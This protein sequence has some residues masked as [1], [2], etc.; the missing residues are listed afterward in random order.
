MESAKMM[1]EI[2]KVLKDDGLYLAISYGT[3]ESRMKH[4]TRE[5]VSFTVEVKEVAKYDSEGT[6][7]THYAYLCRKT[8]NQIK[9]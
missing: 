4:F 7:I 3:P 5:H 2:E 6:K 9:D 1:K 8:G